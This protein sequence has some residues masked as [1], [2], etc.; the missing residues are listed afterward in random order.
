M[1]AF[2]NM[3][4]YQDMVYCHPCGGQIGNVER[5]NL[6]MIRHVRLVRIDPSSTISI[7]VGRYRD[8]NGNPLL[9]RHV[10]YMVSVENRI[11]VEVQPMATASYRNGHRL[12]TPC[13]YANNFFLRQ[14]EINVQSVANVNVQLHASANDQQPLNLSVRASS[15]VSNV[16]MDSGITSSVMSNAIELTGSNNRRTVSSVTPVTSVATPPRTEQRSTSSKTGSKS[17]KKRI[18][19]SSPDSSG[20]FLGPSSRYGDTQPST[21]TGIIHESTNKTDKCAP[22]TKRSKKT[23][24][25]TVSTFQ[26]CF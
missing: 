15:Q 12:A 25:K 21:S 8:G 19:G 22:A 13:P 14:D 3:I 26:Q 7:C 6:L 20:M 17:T 4:P 16:V 5:G 1:D 10:P 9:H 2:V 24:T 11:S 23:A 18:N